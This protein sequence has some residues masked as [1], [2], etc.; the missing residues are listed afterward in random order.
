MAASAP[1]TQEP[2]TTVVRA[3]AYSRLARLLGEDVTPLT[4][5]SGIEELQWCLDVLEVDPGGALDEVAGHAWDPDTLSLDRTTLFEQGRV[6]P[7]EMSYLP[8]G[9][10]GHVGQLADVSGFYRAFGFR[11]EGERPDHVAAELEFAAVL[12][13]ATAHATEDGNDDAAAVCED[14][15]R[16]FLRDHL[17]CWLDRYARRLHAEAAGTPYPALVETAALFVA[18][19]AR[20]LGVEPYQPVGLLAGDTETEEDFALECGSCPEAA[21]LAGEAPGAPNVREG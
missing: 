16:K 2:N 19:E 5:G 20:R 13:L 6:A 4:D 7:Y 17:G 9:P 14:A 3:A 15:Y 21:R 12:A 18:G 11:V 8:A 1:T 10:A